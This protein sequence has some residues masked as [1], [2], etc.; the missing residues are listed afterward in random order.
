[1]KIIKI[2]NTTIF[3]LSLF[4]GEKVIEIRNKKNVYE[5]SFGFKKMKVFPPP[6]Y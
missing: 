2:F 6:R 3:V 4:N 5:F 1:M